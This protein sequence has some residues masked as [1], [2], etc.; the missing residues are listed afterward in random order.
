MVETGVAGG[1][2]HQI[3]SIIQLGG[4]NIRHRAAQPLCD[5]RRLPKLVLLDQLRRRG[6]NSPTKAVKFLSGGEVLVL[7]GV[8]AGG[9]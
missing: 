4:T 3:V 7:L 6:F 9:D 1:Q 2:P 8:E 5:A